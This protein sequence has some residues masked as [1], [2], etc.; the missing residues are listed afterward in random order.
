MQLNVTTTTEGYDKEPVGRETTGRGNRVLEVLAGLDELAASISSTAI[1]EETLWY[2]NSVAF[3][4]LIFFSLY[5]I[6]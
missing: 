5:L 6:F 4:S 1:K 2:I 3:L